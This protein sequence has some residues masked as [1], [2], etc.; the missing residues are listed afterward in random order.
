MIGLNCPFRII[1]HPL[2]YFTPA[3]SFDAFKCNLNL[4][5][6]V[7]SHDFPSRNLI[8]QTCVSNL[9]SNTMFLGV[10]GVEGDGD[11]Y[12]PDNLLEFQQFVFENTNQQGLHFMMADGVSVLLL[13]TCIKFLSHV[14]NM[15]NM[16]F[17]GSDVAFPEK[18]S[19]GNFPKTRK[20]M[21]DS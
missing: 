13:F 7:V 2:L 19:L 12:R 9:D 3:Y 16:L 21:F 5:I 10:G 17:C 8:L 4:A 14:L 20:N 11:V 18:Y 15:L 6:S 1:L